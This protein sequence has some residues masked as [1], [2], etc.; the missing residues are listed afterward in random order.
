MR[1]GDIIVNPWVQKLHDGAFNPMY[2]TIYIGNNQSI[3]F[4]GRKHKWA[5][6]VSSDPRWKVIGHCEL[7]QFIRGRILDA[8]FYNYDERESS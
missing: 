4:E 7:I 5:D 2:A 3:D 1:I 6:K 8:A